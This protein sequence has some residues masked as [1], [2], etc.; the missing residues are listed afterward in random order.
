MHA[1]RT[2]CGCAVVGLPALYA[3]ALRLAAAPNSAQ[4][5]AH[6]ELLQCLPCWTRGRH[7]DRE[8]AVTSLLAALLV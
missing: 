6:G 4:V 2:S 7:R 1:R 8:D 3:G 5:G